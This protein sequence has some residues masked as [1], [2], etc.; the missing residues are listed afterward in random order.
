MTSEIHILLLQ[1][2]IDL[3]AQIEKTS[4]RT[5]F[6]IYFFD[7]KGDI[8]DF[9]HE[10]EIKIIIIDLEQKKSDGLS[11]LKKIKSVD[12]L[13]NVILLGKSLSSEQVIG[14]LNQGAFAYLTKPV[15]PKEIQ[16]SLNKIIEIRNL[17][18]D[19][20][21]LERKLE[22]KYYFH[23]GI[24][25]VCDKRETAV[26]TS[27]DGTVISTGGD[28]IFTQFREITLA[29]KDGFQT[30]Y[31]HLDSVYVHQNQQVKKGQII[32]HTPFCVH[33]ELFKDGELI[34]PEDHMTLEKKLIRKVIKE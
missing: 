13:I 24:D 5:K 34:D 26:V 4:A 1:K 32:G 3:C 15:K 25:I 20:Y 30:R 11:L 23:K 19:T 31:L 29:H 8:L 14:L 27:A 17:R 18:R 22:K 6:I 33:F 12:P 21:T 28:E 9:I 7:N 16:S 10:N 2:D